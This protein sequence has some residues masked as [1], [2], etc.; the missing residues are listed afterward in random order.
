MTA[1]NSRTTIDDAWESRAGLTPANAPDEL[2]DAVE[3]VIADLD[4][5]QLRVAEQG[6]RPVDRRTSGSRRRCCCP[7]A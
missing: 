4:A 1:M 6:V 5:G 7:S 2:R 3:H